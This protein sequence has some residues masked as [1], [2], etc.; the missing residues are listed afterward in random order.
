M[1]ASADIL[2]CTVLHCCSDRR[3]GIAD[4]IRSV[5]YHRPSMHMLPKIVTRYADVTANS[6]S[7]HIYEGDVSGVAEPALWKH[8]PLPKITRVESYHS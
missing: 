7:L 2:L 5:Q 8:K 4:V 1:H 3:V 6:A